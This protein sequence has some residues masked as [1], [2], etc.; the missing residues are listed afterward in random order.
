VPVLERYGRSRRLGAD[1]SWV[2]VHR[3][4]MSMWECAS[5]YLSRHG[6]HALWG[7]PRWER[8]RGGGEQTYRGGG[9]M[10]D[11]QLRCGRGHRP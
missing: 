3:Q 9:I 8:V 4:F 7:E 5:E 6:K 11:D 10:A 2:L 1:D